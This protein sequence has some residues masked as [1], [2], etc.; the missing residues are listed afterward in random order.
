M[1]GFE[2]EMARK[3][4]MDKKI[5]SMPVVTCG[6]GKSLTEYRAAKQRY[7]RP[8]EILQSTTHFVVLFLIIGGS[9]AATIA[10]RKFHEEYE[11]E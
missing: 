5:T 1:S 3:R 11:K 2:K 4:Y 8:E 7:H 9:K 6:C 10:C